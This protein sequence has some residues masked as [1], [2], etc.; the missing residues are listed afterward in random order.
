MELQF[1]DLVATATEDELAAEHAS[2]ATTVKSF[3]RRRSSRKP[4]SEHPPRER[5]VIAAPGSCACCGS[6]R[7]SKLGEDVTET[8]EVIPRQWKVIQTV[9]EKFSWAVRGD[10]PAAGAVPSHAAWLRRPEPACHGAVR[11]VRPAPTVEPAE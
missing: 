9:G 10:Q 4:F 1:E 2:R 5:G 6:T 3:E 7:L 8:L 11:E